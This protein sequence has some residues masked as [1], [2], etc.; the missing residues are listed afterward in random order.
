LPRCSG[1]SFSYSRDALGSVV[2]REPG[3]SV[4]TAC[5]HL[6]LP[7]RLR[8]SVATAAVAPPQPRA[9]RRLASHSR[10]WPR[11]RRTRGHGQD[12]GARRTRRPQPSGSAR[13]RT[14]GHGQD[15]SARRTRRPRP[16]QWRVT[17]CP[18]TMLRYNR[19]VNPRLLKKQP[20][21]SHKF[22]KHPNIIKQS[23]TL[24][25]TLHTPHSQKEDAAESMKDIGLARQGRVPVSSY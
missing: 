6:L 14:R 25:P 3:R 8:H 2:A 10:S 1:P 5:G 19:P 24:Q 11:R 23:Q 17:H 16:R 20:S 22:T 21:T 18:V 4:M 12:D 7:P 15:D 13:W 9:R